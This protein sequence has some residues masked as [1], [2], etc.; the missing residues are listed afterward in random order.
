MRVRVSG[1]DPGV[2]LVRNL[3]AMEFP[4]IV[5]AF[6]VLFVGIPVITRLVVRRR[7]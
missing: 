6:V 7:P 2:W 5:T 1:H 4:V 3:S